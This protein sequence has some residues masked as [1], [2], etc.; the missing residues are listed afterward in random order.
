MSS[1]NRFM[2]LGMALLVCACTKSPSTDEDN[3]NTQPKTAR[4]AV[5][6]AG[7]IDFPV[8]PQIVVPEIIGI[9]PAQRALETSMQDIIDPVAGI[10]VKPANCAADGALLNDAGITSMDAQGNLSRNG[11]EGIFHVNADG[12][13]TANYEGGVI[14]V[15]ADGGGTINGNGDGGADDGIISV[16]ADGSGTYNGKYGIIVLDGKG[17][18]TWNGDHG[19]IRNQGD[20]SGSWNGPQGI[21]TINADGSGTW[22][23]PHGLVS[24]DGKGNGS[25]GTPARQ[26]KM[27]PI[28]KVAPAGKFPPL[29]KFAP[30][31]APCGFI[32]TL[33][34]QVLFDFDKSD[35]RPDAATVLDTLAVALRKVPAKTIEIRGHTDA[36]G[37]DAYNLNLSERRAK[38]VSMAL[39]QRGAATDASTHGYGESQPVAPN[40]VS[41]QDN[42]AG[43]QLNRRVEIFVRT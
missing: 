11:D 19:V 28:P 13:G 6:S 8:I 2:V 43:R 40:E 32:I 12:S 20:G 21:V 14:V 26:V 39:R 10:S 24:N 1:I 15:N 7:D 22:N 33:N 29:K 41:G 9:G 18:G 5:K 27:A 34:D 23:G 30:L 42:P 38:S 36:K 31:G 3:A 25:I 35:I 4:S 37:S 17:G 16:E